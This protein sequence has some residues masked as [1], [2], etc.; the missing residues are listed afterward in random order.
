MRRRAP[1]SLSFALERV[2]ATLEPA[3]TLARVQGCWADAVGEATA[4]VAT[5]VAESNGVVT[6]AC[7]SSL[8]ANELT[9]METDL[10]ERVNASIADPAVARLR[11][12]ARDPRARLR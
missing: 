1:R 4:A 10:L 6:V 5:P 8:W 9:M 2:T 7:E 12:E 11:F 3:T